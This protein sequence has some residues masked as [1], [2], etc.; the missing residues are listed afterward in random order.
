MQ[1]KIDVMGVFPDELKAVSA[2]KAL[3][4]TPWKP[5]RVH[6]PFPSHKILDALKLKKSRVGYFTLVGGVIGFFSGFALAIYTALQWNLIIQGKPVIGWFSFVVVGF[7][8]TILFSVLGNVLG[9]LLQCRLPDYKALEHYDPRCSGQHFGVVASCAE[10]EK[11]GL[12]DLF[13]QQ[14]GDVNVFN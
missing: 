1:A 7:E 14:G 4:D 11:D 12:I 3:A 6:S 5:D 9:L 8:F 10:S 13:K 2:I